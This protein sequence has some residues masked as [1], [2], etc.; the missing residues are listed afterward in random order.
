MG[1]KE[2]AGGEN[3]NE[4]DV[5]DVEVEDKVK[6]DNNDEY[7]KDND[8]QDDCYDKDDYGNCF[9]HGKQELL[10]HLFSLNI[11]YMY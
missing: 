11:R 8:D 3:V 2:E 9:M 10:C 4:D 1:E 6:D 5:K 7:G